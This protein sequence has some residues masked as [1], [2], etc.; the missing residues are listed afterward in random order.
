MSRAEAFEESMWPESTN[1]NNADT[2]QR[3][4]EEAE[5]DTTCI[6]GTALWTDHPDHDPRSPYG[7]LIMDIVI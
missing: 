2:G 3:Q 4:D 5:C 1:Q 7:L 6:K